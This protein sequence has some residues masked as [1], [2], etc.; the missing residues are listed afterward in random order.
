VGQPESYA[1]TVFNC[2]GS[3]SIKAIDHQM[4]EEFSDFRRCYFGWM[5]LLVE[6]D[7]LSN[8]IDVGLFGAIT[9]KA[10]PED[11]AYAI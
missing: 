2:N 9:V 10:R 7:V 6:D 8:P 3:G 4:G 11:I 1:E 5:S